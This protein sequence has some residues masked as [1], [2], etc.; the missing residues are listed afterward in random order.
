MKI[1]GLSTKVLGA[2]LLL[3]LA[4]NLFLGGMLV[5][6]LRPHQG[7]AEPRIERMIERM[8]AALPDADARILRQVYGVHQVQFDQVVAEL[9]QSRDEVRKVMGAN[10]FDSHALQSAFAQQ[11]QRRQAIHEAIH[12]VLVEAAPQL[13]PEGRKK[14]SEWRKEARGQ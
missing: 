11:R 4:I 5:S 14:L 1:A 10:P 2:G 3:S 8:A 9:Q 7:G 13:S 6:R 12:E